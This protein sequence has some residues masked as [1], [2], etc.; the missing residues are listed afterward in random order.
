MMAYEVTI[1][2]PVYNVEKYIRRSLDSAL[3]QTFQ[4]IEFL[5]CDDCG[6][7]SSIDIVREYQHN[8]PRGS[9]IHIVHQPHNKGVGEARNLMIDSAKGKYIYFMDADDVITDDAISILYENAV[10]YQADIVYGSHDRIE[11][12]DNRTD[13]KP[14]VYPRQQF[15][16]ENEF[17]I[18]VYEKYG[19]IETTTWNFLIDIR[20]FRDNGIR[21]KPINFWEDLTT[22]IDLPTYVSRAVLLPNITYKYY[23]RYGSLSNFQKRD[24]IPK[25]EIE[26]TIGAIENVKANGDRIRMKPYYPE[27]CLKVMMTCF[28]MSCSIIKNREIT[29]PSFSDK[30]IRSL[31]VF[32]LSFSE[33]CRF[34]TSRLKCL[35]F[36]LLGIMPSRL[37]VALIRI[38][39]K[40]K[41]LI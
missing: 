22:T 17:A 12:F 31:M 36:Y 3:A 9:D 34:R 14:Y 40:K 23:C 19:R 20:I 41:G 29:H 33:I 28:Y 13:I 18:W 38:L 35:A 27:R 5:V 10:R 25:E 30:E 1:G 15:L 7:D 26:K 39:G 16:N 6:T 8:H 32:P 11:E 37:T 21:Y 2:I 24:I 4:S